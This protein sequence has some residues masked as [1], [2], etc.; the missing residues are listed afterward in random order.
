MSKD[1]VTAAAH[2]ASLALRAQVEIIVTHWC[3]YCGQ[4]SV[5]ERIDDE[6][7][8]PLCSN[9]PRGLSAAD[10]PASAEGVKS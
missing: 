8:C 6:I 2:G 9:E 5:A 3:S 4:T 10:A 1:D 7:I